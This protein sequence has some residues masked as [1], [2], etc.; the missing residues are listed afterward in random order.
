MKREKGRTG[1]EATLF[2]ATAPSNTAELA[3]GVLTRCA[4]PKKSAIAG[5]FVFDFQ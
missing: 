2:C 3:Y 1:G 4:K 5:R